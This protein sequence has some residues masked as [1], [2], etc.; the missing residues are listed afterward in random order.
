MKFYS[1]IFLL[2]FS[3]VVR[4]QF[5][6][7]ILT[8]LDAK[9]VED[10]LFFSDDNNLNGYSSEV[11]KEYYREITCSHSEGIFRVVQS[12]PD[13]DHI[14][15]FTVNT[16][17][18]DLIT[19]GNTI[20]YY[21]YL[22]ELYGQQDLKG[23]QLYDTLASFQSDTE[24]VELNLAFREIFKTDINMND[25]FQTNC[26]FGYRCGFIG[27]P[28]SELEYINSLVAT[29]DKNAIR[30]WLTSPNTEKQVF[31]VYGFVALKNKGLI[32]TEEEKKIIQ[33]IIGKQGTMLVCSG[34][35]FMSSEIAKVTESFVI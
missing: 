35:F 7:K 34:C 10:L 29:N 17:R 22:K 15:S 25:F 32:I 2:M 1:I 33:F 5:E 26:S 23:Q 30:A 11:Q 16:Y 24:L 6:N 12:I 9:N 8:L 14:N 18:I 13:P 19:N 3:E 31:A 27:S 28:V 21:V 4:A 20:I